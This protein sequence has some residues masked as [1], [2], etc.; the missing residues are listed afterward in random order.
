MSAEAANS[1]IAMESEFKPQRATLPVPEEK[2]IFGLYDGPIEDTKTTEWDFNSRLAPRRRTERKAWIYLGIFSRDFYA[3]IAIAD[4]GY[5]GTAFSYVYIPAEKRFIEDKLTLPLGFN[6]GFDATLADSWR[7]G[8]YE[9]LPSRERI[10]VNF[11]GADYDLTA[12]FRLTGNGLSTIAPAQNRPFNFTY[13]EMGLFCEG[14][15][16][17]NGKRQKFS[18]EYGILDYT[19]GYPARRTEWN[20]LSMI[21]KTESGKSLSVNLVDKF[22]DGIENALW[23]DGKPMGLSSAHFHYIRPAEKSIWR[24]LTRDNVFEAR[25]RP[26]GARSEDLNMGFL[27]SKFVQPYGVFD[28]QVKIDGVSERFTGYGVTEDHLAVW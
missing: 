8:S 3:G 10:V 16:S 14:E 9:I 25:F 12:M 22:N 6:S 13:K 17:Q 19:K 4:A 2:N 5:I 23:L 26:F 20:W 18:G 24:I 7:L 15:F 1:P 11:R 27:K 21:G 28:G